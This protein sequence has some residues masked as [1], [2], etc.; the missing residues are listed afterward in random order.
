MQQSTGEEDDDAAQGTVLRSYL[1]D[2]EEEDE[3][4]KPVLPDTHP[5]A[6]P[7]TPPNAPSIP[8]LDYPNVVRPAVC[9]NPPHDRH[10]PPCGT[11]SP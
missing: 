10:P 3:V 4:Y 6:P 7:N 9:R 1:V 8:P 5:D 2:D 11:H